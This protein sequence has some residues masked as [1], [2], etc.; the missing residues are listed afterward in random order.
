MPQITLNVNKDQIFS[1]GQRLFIVESERTA[2]YNSKCPICD[3]THKITVR[4]VEFDC[5]MCRAA[6]SGQSLQHISV[7]KFVTREYFINELR[8]FGEENKSDYGNNM[9]PPTV[10]YKAFTRNSASYNGAKTRSV[11]DR[12]LDPSDEN[13]IDRMEDW[14]FSTKAKAECYRKMLIQRDKERLDKF[15]ELNGTD[16]VYPFD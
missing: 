7:H 16:Y 3:D 9:V 12:Q 11:Y 4:G 1:F 10:A 14:V 5:P 6:R 2:D 13:I 15:N 8:I